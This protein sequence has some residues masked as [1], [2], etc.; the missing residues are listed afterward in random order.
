MFKKILL[1][2]LF[3]SLISLQSISIY[4]DQNKENNLNIINLVLIDEAPAQT[5]IDCFDVNENHNVVIATES[6][7]YKKILI[8]NNSGG[9]GRYM[10]ISLTDLTF[11]ASILA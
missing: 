8:Y 6:S 11:R 9:I 2:L 4:A 10:S 5:P 7:F 1:V 3:F